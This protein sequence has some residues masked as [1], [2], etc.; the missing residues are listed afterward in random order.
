MDSDRLKI[1]AEVA[2][3]RGRGW[4]RL[5]TRLLGIAAVLIGAL[6][7]FG[8]ELW[9]QYRVWLA[10]VAGVSTGVGFAYLADFLFIG[11]GAAVANFV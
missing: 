3:I 7:F 1:T 5:L 10:Q 9:T 4:I 11:A 6:N 8:F 2:A